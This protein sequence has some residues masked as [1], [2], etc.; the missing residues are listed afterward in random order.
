MLE[1]ADLGNGA[2]FTAQA[3]DDDL[4]DLEPG[5]AV[6]SWTEPHAPLPSILPIRQPRPISAPSGDVIVMEL[7][8]T[9]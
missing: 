6:S 1:A 3:G 7:F 4:E 2:T 8:A 5:G 9:Y